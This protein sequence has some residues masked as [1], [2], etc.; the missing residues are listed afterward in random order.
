M[1]NFRKTVLLAGALLTL[2][3]T[4]LKADNSKVIEFALKNQKPLVTAVVQ[5]PKKATVIAQGRKQENDGTTEAAQS[6]EKYEER[7]KNVD[8]AIFLCLGILVLGVAAPVVLLYLAERR[9]DAGKKGEGVDFKTTYDD[10]EKP[11]FWRKDRKGNVY[12]G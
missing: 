8:R 4:Q 2:G 12:V 7:K 10:A 5:E 9:D 6:Q 11:G 1:T 3:S